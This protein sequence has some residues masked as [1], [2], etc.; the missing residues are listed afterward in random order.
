MAVKDALRRLVGQKAADAPGLPEPVYNPVAYTWYYDQILAMDESEMWRTQPQLRTVISFLARNIAQ[1]GVHTFARV[2]DTDRR[3]VV[4]SAA[5]KLLAKPNPE[6]TGYELLLNLVA[7]LALY[8]KAYWYIT[9]DAKF[10]DSGWRITRIPPTWV[11]GIVA[12]GLFGVKEFL[13]QPT[14]G[15]T[16]RQARIPAEKMIYFHGW[17]PDDPKFGDSPVQA[18]RQTLAEQTAAQ[19]FRNQNWR[20][21]G[22]MQGV[23]ERP[24]E[25]PDWS[26]DAKE[27]FRKGW[28]DA[29][30]GRHGTDA[31]GTPILEDG[32]SYKSVGFSAADN[33]FVETAKLSLGTV[34]GV[35]HIN[36][37]MVGD[38]AGANYSNVREFR[39]ALYGDTLGATIAQLEARINAFLLP[40]IDEP[41][42]HYV[43]FNIAE[44]LQG[45]FEDQAVALQMATG[46]PWMAVNEAR[47]KNNMPNL[48]PEYD[49]IITPLNVVRGGGSQA[50]PQDSAPAPGDRTGPGDSQ[51]EQQP[52]SELIRAFFER[53]RQVVASKLGA[54]L[55]LDD[56]WNDARWNSEL[57]ELIPNAAEVNEATKTALSEALTGGYELGLVAAVFERAARVQTVKL[58]AA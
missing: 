14:T 24:A 30:S 39:K 42:Q 48:G 44:K 35:Y 29:Y 11:N 49:E 32:M 10:G 15:Q 43:E 7:D 58:V 46:G 9:R 47:A 56:A 51:P 50:N 25:A 38:N 12:A 5:A 34:C 40:M 2:H 20:N 41:D 33:Q 8:D 27:K 23:I 17:N 52:K 1:L 21:G 6:M 31:G 22:R 3:R 36:P 19:E 4:E 55:S 54:G 28:K 53:Q 18:L 26:K 16:S 45:N 13:V 37:I 57:A